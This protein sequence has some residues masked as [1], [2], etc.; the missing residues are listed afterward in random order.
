MDLTTFGRSTPRRAL[1]I[2]LAFFFFV[3]PRLDAFAPVNFLWAPGSNRESILVLAVSVQYESRHGRG[4]GSRSSGDHVVTCHRGAVLARER[5]LLW[6]CGFLFFGAFL[7]RV[8]LTFEGFSPLVAWSPT[9]RRRAD[10]IRS[11]S[12]QRLRSPRAARKTRR[13]SRTSLVARLVRILCGVLRVAPA[14]HG[15]TDPLASYDDQVDA[16]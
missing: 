15:P 9:Q 16:R 2:L 1:R 7:L 5:Q 13:D 14:S 12:A 10:S 6:I 3:V 8:V 4:L 11:P